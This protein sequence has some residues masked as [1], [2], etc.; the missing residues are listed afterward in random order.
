MD[1]GP[2]PASAQVARLTASDSSYSSCLTVVVSL[3][4]LLWARSSL[5]LV[6]GADPRGD[7]AHQLVHVLRSQSVFRVNL[8]RGRATVVLL[9]DDEIVR[10][11]LTV[12]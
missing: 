4:R 8:G 7:F 5:F 2:G 3:P 9:D 6:A 11:Y 10:N 1:A 12:S